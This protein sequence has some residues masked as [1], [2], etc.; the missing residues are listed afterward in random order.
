MLMPATIK[1]TGA[2]TPN[3]W[4]FRTARSLHSLDILAVPLIV[5]TRADPP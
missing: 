2:T 1:T 4:I 3:N 5:A